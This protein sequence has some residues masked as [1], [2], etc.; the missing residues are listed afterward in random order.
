MSHRDGM[1]AMIVMTGMGAIRRMAWAAALAG[2]AG[3]C[4]DFEPLPQC[5]SALDCPAGSCVDGT[6]RPADAAVDAAAD[7]EPDGDSPAPP[8]LGPLCARPDGWTPV[9]ASEGLRPWALSARNGGSLGLMVGSADGVR[10]GCLDP[11]PAAPRL[12]LSPDSHVFGPADDTDHPVLRY[13][14]REWIIGWRPQPGTAGS[15]ARLSSDLGCGDPVTLPDIDRLSLPSAGPALPEPRPGAVRID[16]A[17]TLVVGADTV[18][19]T[20]IFLHRNDRALPLLPIVSS[21]KPIAVAFDQPDPEPALAAVLVAG[22]R[23]GAAGDLRLHRCTLDTIP[24]CDTALL[25]A[26]DVDLVDAAL[27][28]HP[29]SGRWLV[30]WV[31]ELHLR[32]A[33]VAPLEGAFRVESLLDPLPLPASPSTFDAAVGP[34]GLLVALGTASPQG[35]GEMSAVLLDPVGELHAVTLAEEPVEAAAVAWDGGQMAYVMAWAPVA[36][37]DPVAPAAP[38]RAASFP[39]GGS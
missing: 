16:A 37:A 36:S 7:L 33:V 4:I 12:S 39:C 3:G 34:A 20:R 11:D 23:L 25:V 19:D 17:G 27:A 10:L 29:E 21:E 22:A 30:A 26:Q 31:D 24:S 15:L 14:G 32:A 2:L 38:M 1:G 6:C 13:A 28:W 5:L 8:G 35:G 9:R 18:P